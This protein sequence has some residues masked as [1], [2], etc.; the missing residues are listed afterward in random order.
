MSRGDAAALDGY[1]SSD[2]VTL[3]NFLRFCY[4]SSHNGLPTQKFEQEIR[5]E[6]VRKY[7]SSKLLLPNA[8][9]PKYACKAS[10]AHLID[11]RYLSSRI[12]LH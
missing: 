9:V 10:S 7:G 4:C 6:V 2:R 12:L 5:M 11:D 8:C 1:L 3:E